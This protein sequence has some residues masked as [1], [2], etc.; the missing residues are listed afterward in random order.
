MGRFLQQCERWLDFWWWHIRSFVEP[1]IC[2]VIVKLLQLVRFSIGCNKLSFKMNSEKNFFQ[3]KEMIYIV[4]QLQHTTFLFSA[5]VP[6][7]ETFEL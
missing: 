3:E 4:C 1:D 2:I 5:Y 6:F 7:N